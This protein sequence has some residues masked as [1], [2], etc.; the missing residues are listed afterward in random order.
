MIH[1]EAVPR[2]FLGIVSQDL[3]DSK[4]SR[5]HVDLIFWFCFHPFEVYSSIR[6]AFFNMLDLV[7]YLSKLLMV[8]MHVLVTYWIWGREVI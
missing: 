7:W 4:S 6:N 3:S 1:L 2:E 8:N 5:L